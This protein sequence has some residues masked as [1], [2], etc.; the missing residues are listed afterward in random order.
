MLVSPDASPQE[1]ATNRGLYALSTK[2]AIS[3]RL[4]QPSILN[5]CSRIA[6]NRF[7]GEFHHD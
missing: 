5:A 4:D 2:P 7:S 3:I 6:A 1:R